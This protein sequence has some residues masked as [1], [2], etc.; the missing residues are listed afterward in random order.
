MSIDAV[1]LT[2]MR[3]ALALQ[4][5]RSFSNAARMCHVTQST[6]SIQMQKMEELLG[7]ALFDRIKKPIQPTATG[8]SL[9]T[10]F[11]Q[12][13][14]ATDAIPAV[15]TQSTQ[16]PT[17]HLRIGIIPTVAPALTATLA[18]P[19]GHQATTSPAGGV[20]PGTL[21]LSLEETQTG[22][23]LERLERNDLDG[24]ILADTP[25]AAWMH[26]TLLY[27]E[28]FLVY[29]H[30][31]HP[32]VSK[33][34]LT[35]EDLDPQEVWIL[36]EGHCFGTQSMGLCAAVRQTQATTRRLSFSAGSFDT[37]VDL[38]HAAGGF[39]LLPWLYCRRHNLLQKPQTK[40]FASPRPVRQ[41]YY[42]RHYG[43]GNQNA[44][45]HL[46]RIIQE[47]LPVNLRP[48]PTSDGAAATKV[49]PVF[50]KD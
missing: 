49:V 3:Y 46:C 39:T 28:E 15:I 40:V 34:L 26:A 45:E 33:D 43:S 41:I 13:I 22:S 11:R 14:A 16:N 20:A 50:S 47:S 27:E 23:L 19:F 10:I 35:P 2:Q 25:Q 18:L 9:L 32:L 5:T 4:E 21:S 1:T 48:T 29:L 37:L 44:H 6:L 8:E 30:P 17:G 38:V 42:V 36:K 24:G 7:V 31:Q 12:I